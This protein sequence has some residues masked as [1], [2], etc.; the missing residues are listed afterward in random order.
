MTD[1]MSKNA[2]AR[3]LPSVGPE[4]AEHLSTRDLRKAF[5][6]DDLFHPGELR[7][8]QTEIDRFIIGGATPIEPLALPTL[9]G[10][11]DESFLERR[12]MG[13]INLGGAGRVRIGKKTFP[14]VQQDCLYVG[15]GESDIWFETEEG[16]SATFYFVSCPAHGLHPTALARKADAAVIPLGNPLNASKREICQY[17]HPAGLKSSQL[18]MGMTQLGP[19]SVWN[20]MPAHTHDRRSEIY[21][22]DGLGDENLVIH[23]MGRPEHTRSL[24]VRD[25][26]AVLSPSWSVHTGAGTSNYRFIWAMA[27]ENQDFNDVAPLPLSGLF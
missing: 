5:L 13:I 8:V 2:P 15:A 16:Q 7:L 23:L 18:M 20:T 24:I 6:V 26:Q 10:G 9:P 25:R 3:S 1:S 21:L 11:H 27:G 4:A 12:E 17:I 22:Y 14:L 19:G